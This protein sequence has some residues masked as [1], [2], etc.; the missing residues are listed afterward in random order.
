MCTVRPLSLILLFQHKSIGRPGASL[1]PAAAVAEDAADDDP[2][3]TGGIAPIVWMVT[4]SIGIVGCCI[5]MAL[6]IAHI[7]SRVTNIGHSLSSATEVLAIALLLAGFT[8]LTLMC[9]MADRIG[10]LNTLFL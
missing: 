10:A 3:K 7:V 8:R 9:Y 5:S 2:M 1:K 4:L 6:P